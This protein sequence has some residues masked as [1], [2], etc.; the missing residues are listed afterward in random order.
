MFLV[1]FHNSSLKLGILLRDEFVRR[2]VRVVGIVF[3]HVVA[4]FRYAFQVLKKKKR[5]VNVNVKWANEPR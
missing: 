2:Q 1:I 5:N 3:S 4:T